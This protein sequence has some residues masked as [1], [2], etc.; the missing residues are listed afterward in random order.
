MVAT[1]QIEQ[2]TG[3]FN[4]E[5]WTVKNTEKN[6]RYYT[7]DTHVSSSSD[8]PIPIPLTNDGYSGS[9]WVTNCINVTVAPSTYIKD[10]RYYQTWSTDPVTDWTLGYKGNMLIG[11]SS[12][13]IVAART[14]TQGFPSSS[15]VQ[16]TGSEGVYGNWISS[17]HT[18]YNTAASAVSGGMT[19]VMDFND[20]NN[21]YMV[22]SGQVV[23]AATGRSYCIA[24]QVRVGSGATQGEKADKTATFVFSEV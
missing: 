4:S 14:V 13:T 17:N 1:V 15:Y 21:A 10:L 9:Y 12:A 3:A 20:L 22:Q 19:I 11:V 24:T 23:G 16:S 6:V 5:T 2:V 18:Y 8:N 7:A